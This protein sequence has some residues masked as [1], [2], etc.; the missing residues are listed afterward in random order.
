[1]ELVLRG[2]V[3]L[4]RVEALEREQGEGQAEW[5]ARGPAQ[6]PAEHACAP[7]VELQSPTRPDFPATSG[8]ARSV[9]R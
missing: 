5:E 4:V 3:D 9:G 6:A 2:E 1:M 8:A 7:A